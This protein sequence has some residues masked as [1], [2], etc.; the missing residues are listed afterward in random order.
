MHKLTRA[1]GL[2]IIDKLFKEL[3]AGFT[4]WEFSLFNCFFFEGN[5]GYEPTT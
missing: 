4:C 1:T 5:E 2:S 3:F